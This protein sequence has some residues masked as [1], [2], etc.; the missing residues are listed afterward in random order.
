LQAFYE[1]L[2]LLNVNYIYQQ[3]LL[4]IIRGSSMLNDHFDLEKKIIYKF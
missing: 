4:G 1:M 3:T 2:M